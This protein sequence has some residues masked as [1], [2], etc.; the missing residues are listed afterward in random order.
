MSDGP[1]PNFGA[2]LRRLRIAAGLSQEVLAERARLSAKAI[3]ALECG[4]RLAPYRTTVASLA[5]ALGLSAAERGELEAARG[6]RE[7]GVVSHGMPLQPTSALDRTGAFFA[8]FP[9]PRN[10]YFTGREDLLQQVRGT[11]QECRR[12]ALSGLGGVG[13]TQVALEYAYRH[14]DAYDQVFWI[15]AET[16]STI[17][18]GFV[19]MAELLEFPE[20]A[21][22]EKQRVVAAV[23]GWLETHDSWLLVADNIEEPHLLRPFLPRVVNG[24]LLVTSRAQILSPLGITNPLPIQEF[25][26]NE[27]LQ[28]LLTRTGREG[29]DRSERG[30]AQTLAQ[31][32]GY[33]PLA[34]EQAAAY[35]HENASRFAGYLKSY[36]TRRLEL[37]A[38]GAPA[39]DPAKSVTTTWRIAFDRIEATPASA[40]LL[41]ASAFL[42]PNRIPLELVL[43]GAAE[44]GPAIAQALPDADDDLAL[45]ELLAPLTRYSLILREPE[46]ETYSLHRLV[47]EVT[48]DN[49][50]LQMRRT[51][52]ERV[53]A[54]VN[55]AFPEV[56]YAA[57]NRCERLL[58]HAQ[59]AAELVE[60]YDLT[61]E[62]AARLLQEAARYLHE[63]ARY[64]EAERLCQRALAI[65][66]QLLGPEHPDFA[67]SLNYLGNLYRQTCRYAEAEPA[68]RRSLTIRKRVL[69]PDH[70][71]VA[72]SMNNLAALYWDQGRYA[73]AEPL[74]NEA[75]ATAERVLGPRH[76]HVAYIINNLAGLYTTLG[77]YTEVE[78]LHIRSLEI[79]EHVL[80]P[81]HPDVAASLNNLAELYGA[82]G[83]YPEAESLH[84]RA[85]S[86]REQALGS[87]HP[88][89]A[90]SMINLGE[91]HHKQGCYNDAEPLYLRALAIFEHA[92]GPDHPH[93]ALC[94]NELAELYH[95]QGRYVEAEPLYLRALRIRQQVLKPEHP[96][97][98]TTLKGLAELYRAQGRYAD[99]ERLHQHA[100]PI[101]PVAT[102]LRE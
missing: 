59:A 52:A 60:T 70:R 44:L 20:H 61:S 40:D 95:A 67:L 88:E 89:V 6:R 100:P 68:Y 76:R 46:S 57:W 82:Q 39:D 19:E 32:V 16:E 17:T 23:K 13:K 4:A 50:D 22:T 2:V 21:T 53:V 101:E 35:I 62:V 65:R 38:R 8:T 77:R 28:F 98:T 75:L 81:R 96:D 27:A 37:L 31:E 54:A 63:R 10:P 66:E 30:A 43:E 92:L 74:L 5:A 83:R 41:R 14:S 97:V 93:V 45:D 1:A 24:H 36:C 25:S 56:E 86:I 42:R 47:Q 18:G 99:A 64:A 73:E 55:R 15:R 94:L 69:G 79:R 58:A 3:S 84:K 90:T 78:R 51:W 72:Q 87:K 34:L 85:L 71:D 26:P 48:R 11:L 49:I 12:V 29:A 91:L 102:S 7:R 33:L 80:G 9:S